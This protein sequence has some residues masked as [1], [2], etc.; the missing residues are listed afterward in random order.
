[1]AVLMV[2]WIALWCVILHSIASISLRQQKGNEAA[3]IRALHSTSVIHARQ[4][5]PAENDTCLQRHTVET[6][7]WYEGVVIK[8]RFTSV[9]W[10]NSS[11]LNY[12]RILL[13]C[14]PSAPGNKS[15]RQIIR[16]TWGDQSCFD[17]NDFLLPRVLFVLGLSGNTTQ[18]DGVRQERDKYGDILLFNFDDRYYNL[19]L[20]MLLAMRWVSEKLPSVSHLLKADDDVFLNPYYWMVKIRSLELTWP[21]KTPPCFM[22][23]ILRNTPVLRTGK[24]GVTEK[25]YSHPVYPAYCNGPNYYFNRQAMLAVLGIANTTPLFHLEDVFFTGFLATEAS[26]PRFSV[27][28]ETLSVTRGIAAGKIQSPVNRSFLCLTASEYPAQKWPQAWHL[29]STHRA[30]YVLQSK[31]LKLFRDKDKIFW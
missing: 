30:F 22:G 10:P 8:K 25:M 20:K 23:N 24:W 28:W 19:T 12:P 17:Q 21:N 4:T 11:Q 26:L 31:K 14:V 3:R 6:K 27:F 18:D 5:S 15:S 29:I 2:I 9:M 7:M 1:M 13:I 16:R